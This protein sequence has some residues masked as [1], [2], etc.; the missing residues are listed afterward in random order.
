MEGVLLTLKANRK[1]STVI[2]FFSTSFKMIEV[3][4]NLRELGV[5]CIGVEMQSRKKLKNKRM[6]RKTDCL[7]M[8]S[9]QNDE[10]VVHQTSGLPIVSLII[11]EKSELYVFRDVEIP[12][13]LSDERGL[14]S[15]GGFVGYRF[16]RGHC[17]V[18]S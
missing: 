3:T 16:F 1:S 14:R 2:F 7:N 10:I 17:C 5:S 15:R 8:S 11:G 6:N 12:N 13:Q 4:K 18:V 9:T